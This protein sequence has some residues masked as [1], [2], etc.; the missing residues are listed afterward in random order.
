[1]AALATSAP[2]FDREPSDSDRPRSAA[3]TLSR[4]RHSADTV[5]R[6]RSALHSPNP[7]IRAATMFEMIHSENA[8][9]IAVAINE[10]H[11]SDD[12]VLRDLS[13][14][15]AFGE[16]AMFTIQPIAPSDFNSARLGSVIF[17]SAGLNGEI[18]KYVLESG[19]FVLQDGSGG[20]SSQQLVFHT[21]L[22][23]GQLNAVPG[24]WSYQGVATCTNGGN[25]ASG[26]V[27]VQIR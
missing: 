14:R 2:A 13:A 11:A 22:C 5:A 15:A 21:R 8:L 18:Q 25:S 12:S 20:L 3:E 19:Q 17:G 24:T 7:A 4:A 6:L 16:L 26:N 10:G 23:Y 27:T 9:L 1:M